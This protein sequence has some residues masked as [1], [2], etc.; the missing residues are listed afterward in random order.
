MKEFSQAA[1]KLLTER[2]G[3]PEPQNDVGK[4]T[5]SLV[6][7]AMALGA[8]AALLSVGLID[9]SKLPPALAVKVAAEAERLL[10]KGKES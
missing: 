9:A 6:A 10:D 1:R 5:L 4:I 2:V 3:I 7:E 8:Q